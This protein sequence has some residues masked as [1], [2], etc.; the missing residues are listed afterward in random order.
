MKKTTCKNLAGA[1]D[2]EVQ[3]ETP[4]EMGE[5]SKKHA[6]EMIQSGDEAHKEAAQKM[7]TMSKEDQQKWYE[8]FKNSFDSLQDA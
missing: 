2:F 4:E 3:G 1:C 8:G 6:M 7:M 5:A